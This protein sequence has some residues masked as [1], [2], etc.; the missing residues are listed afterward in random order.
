MSWMGREFNQCAVGNTED[1]YDHTFTIRRHPGCP[2]RGDPEGR[3]SPEA[4]VPLRPSM[5]RRTVCLLCKGF[6][7]DLTTKASQ[8]GCVYRNTFHGLV[9]LPGVG[10][11]L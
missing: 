3:S 4:G 11:V 7:Q 2:D 5:L 8:T 1:N 10:C 9:G 6:G